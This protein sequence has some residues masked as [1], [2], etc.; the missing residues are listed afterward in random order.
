MTVAE[1]IESFLFHCRYEKNLSVRTLKAYA[2][3]LDQFLTGV[4]GSDQG[5]QVADL[6][7]PE[8]RTYIQRLFQ[9][10]RE[11]TIKRKVA[12]LKAL[13]RFLERDEVLDRNPFRTMDVR[14]KE[15]RRLPRI[16]P[17]ADL[18]L[19]FKYLYDELARVPET[20]EDRRILVRDVAVIEALFATGARVFEI[21]SVRTQDVNLPEGWMRI[22]GKG[23]R[24][25]VIHL[26]DP[27]VVAALCTYSQNR[28]PD[29]EYFFVNGRGNRLS[30]QAVR[31]AL[32]KRA[33]RA[34]LA[35]AV[36]PHLIRHTLATLLLEEGVDIRHIQ[37]LLGH[38][39]I[40]TT[41]IYTHVRSRSQREVLAAKH[42]RRTLM[43]A[44]ADG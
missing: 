17:R 23:G 36:R 35:G 43:A 16:I 28:P 2:T 40:A 37:Y 42:P 22:L 41:Q 29:G 11:K 18:Q 30:E 8:L 32:R 24:E 13:F 9:I 6:G 20:S 19:L 27:N 5:V 33:L 25:R 44:S 31:L 26:C 34:G 10:Y 12:T 3:D 4:A 14:I 38:S 7:K 39:S 1:A 21:C 15:K